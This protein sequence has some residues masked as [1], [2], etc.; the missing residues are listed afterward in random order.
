MVDL[1]DGLNL[2]ITGGYDGVDPFELTIEPSAEIGNNQAVGYLKL[3]LL[4]L[5]NSG[6]S[7]ITATDDNDLLIGG[8]GSDSFVFESSGLGSGDA[9]SYDVIQDLFISRH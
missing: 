6:D 5:C 2:A 4:S 8:E 1:V 9:P 7:T 3:H